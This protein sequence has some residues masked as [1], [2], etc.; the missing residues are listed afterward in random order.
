MAIPAKP[1]ASFSVA[2]LL[3][4]I[5]LFSSAP[6]SHGGS[7]AIY[8]GQN[9]NEGT[10]AETCSTGNYGFVNIAFLCS[11]GSGQ[12]P[13]LNLAG[14]C[15]PYSN[16][17]TNLTADINL[18]QSK[19]VKVMLSIGG[20]AGGYTLNSEQDAADLAL[21][22]W[23][24]F[25]GGSSPSSKRPFGDAVLDGV[26]FDIEGGNP[27]YYGALASH[28]KSYSG[29]GSKSKEVYLS[30]APQC[31]FPDQW[32]GKALDT[33]L[34]DYVWVQF[35]NNPPCQFVQGNPANLMDSWKQWTT[36][37]HAKY[38]FL[39]LPAAPAAAGS[40]FI[41]A[42][43][44]ESQVLPALKGSSKYGGVMLWSKFYD[45]QDGYSSAIK[46]SV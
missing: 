20:G 23:N 13:Q 24:S 15:D 26:D 17:C 22:I 41:P 45:D 42:A 10:L 43:S 3:A 34:F 33:G 19:G 32:V 40:G 27:D 7:I 5:F 30:A 9:G 31:P 18:C 44:L 29:K 4:A 12:S 16:A 36:G 28:L 6:R 46:N 25:L 2:C 1:S 39:G 14:H 11:F 38:I 21:Y 35:Y 8:W 37:V